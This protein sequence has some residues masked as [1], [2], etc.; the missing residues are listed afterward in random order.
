MLQLYP[1]DFIDS[2]ETINPTKKLTCCEAT[3]ANWAAPVAN[4]LQP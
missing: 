3:A 4:E 2:K 1:T